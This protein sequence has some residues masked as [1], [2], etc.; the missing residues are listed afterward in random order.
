MLLL[1]NVMLLVSDFYSISL[2][3]PVR[4]TVIPLSRKN[5]AESMIQ[6]LLLT[7]ALL[8]IAGFYSISRIIENS[9]SRMVG[10]TSKMNEEQRERKSRSVA[11]RDK[12]SE[13]SRR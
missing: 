2:I 4:V 1:I 8:L 12:R 5:V 6:K 10:F 11:V 13:V 9:Q 3:L 7:K